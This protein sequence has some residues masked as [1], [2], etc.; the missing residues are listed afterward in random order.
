M[1]PLFFASLKRTKLANQNCSKNQAW[2]HLSLQFF[3]EKKNLLAR[4]QQKE[5]QTY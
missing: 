2:L 3:V 4:K 5:V 1:I